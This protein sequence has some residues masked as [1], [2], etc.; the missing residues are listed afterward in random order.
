[1]PIHTIMIKHIYYKDLSNE[2]SRC[3]KKFHDKMWR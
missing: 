1:M 3:E 2:K